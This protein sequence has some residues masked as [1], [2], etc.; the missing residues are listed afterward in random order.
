MTSDGEARERLRAMTR[1]TVRAHIAETAVDL[2]AERGFDAVTVEEVAA[3][4]GVSARSFHRYFPAKED[5]VIGSPAPWGAA[6]SEAF[7]QRPHGEAV[8]DSL[9]S[10]FGTL[11]GRPD[12]SVDRQK[13]GLRLLRSAPSLRARHLEKQLLWEDLLAPLI[14]TRLHPDDAALRSRVIAKAALACFDAAMTAWVEPDEVRT[15]RELLDAA[16]DGLTLF[17]GAAA[18][19]STRPR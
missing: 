5:A 16:F 10:A 13:R 3:A 1:E 17:A 18:P 8:A 9:R 11:L 4:A 7:A 15:P 19:A 14:E 6:L 12:Q 2:F